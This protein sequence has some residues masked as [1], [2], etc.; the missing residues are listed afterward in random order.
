[1][2]EALLAGVPVIGFRRGVLPSLVTH[3]VTGFVVD[4]E[5]ELA[6]CLRRADGLD[7]AA[8]AEAVREQ[9]APTRMVD[10]YVRLY[11][12]VIRKARPSTLSAGPAAAR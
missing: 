3:G 8:I 9:M 6:D 2:V 7:R 12:E 4:T 1:M 5:D 11:H 10:A